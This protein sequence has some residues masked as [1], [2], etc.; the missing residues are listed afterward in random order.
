MSEKNEIES[1]IEAGKELVKGK[2]VLES[3]THSYHVIP[4]GYEITAIE[5]KK[6]VPERKKGT[7]TFV[8][9]KSFCSYVNKHKTKNQTIIIAD[10]SKDIV[11]AVLNDHSEAAEWGDFQA[12]LKL[13]KSRQ[14]EAWV[15]N[16]DQFV[17]QENFAKFIEDNRSDFMCGVIKDAE[18]KDI[19]NTSAVALN[20]LILDLEYSANETLVSK[21]N[22]QTGERV[23]SY[24]NEQNG[25]C[26]FKLPKTFTLA[27]PIFKNGDPFQITVNLRTRMTEGSARFG[28]NIDQ[29]HEN[30]E[31]AFDGICDRITIGVVETRLIVDI[32]DPE[33]ADVVDDLNSSKS[34]P[35]TEIE[36]FRGCL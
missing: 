30:I 1:A 22:T 2:L 9:A 3:D 35:G 33:S 17:G 24:S 31:K 36:V 11:R 12:D 19:E 6:T 8:S 14:W 29:M 4:K 18:G 27:I 13:E 34:Y 16:S 32:E 7:R 21:I 20:Q 28:F 26:S 10:E 23:Y 15:N 5:H 25:N